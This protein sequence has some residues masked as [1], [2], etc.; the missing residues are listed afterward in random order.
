MYIS[1]NEDYI[2][3]MLKLVEQKENEICSLF[4]LDISPD[5]L[6]RYITEISGTILSSLLS[7]KYFFSLHIGGGNHHATKNRRDGFCVFNDITIAAYFFF[8]AFS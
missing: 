2:N 3:A 6:C 4:E 7:V 5:F 8:L 1:H